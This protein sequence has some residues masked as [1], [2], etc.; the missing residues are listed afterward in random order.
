MKAQADDLA[1]HRR[2]QERKSR[3]SRWP[4]VELCYSKA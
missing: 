1:G 2:V 4:K 3:Q